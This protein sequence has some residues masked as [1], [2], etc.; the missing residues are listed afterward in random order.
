MLAVLAQQMQALPG[1]A[2]PAGQHAAPPQL[3][4]CAAAPAA[5]GE[6]A[7]APAFSALQGG[8]SAES[9]SSQARAALLLQACHPGCTWQRRMTRLAWGDLHTEPPRCL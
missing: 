4:A 3:P 2:H 5:F 1:L 9:S 8:T 7:H 6:P